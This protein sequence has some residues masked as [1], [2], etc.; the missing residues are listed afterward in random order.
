[1]K[2]VLL[3]IVA[4]TALAGA[5]P[6]AQDPVV[7]APVATPVPLP[8]MRITSPLG[9]TSTSATLRIVRVGYFYTD[10]KDSAPGKPVF[11]RVVS[12]RDG[13]AKK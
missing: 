2:Q 7:P 5:A 10:P 13:F 1:M 11:N 8:T 9:R 12:L 3:A 6:H 4:V